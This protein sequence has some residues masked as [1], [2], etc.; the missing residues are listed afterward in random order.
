MDADALE[1]DGYA[2]PIVSALRKGATGHEI[3]AVLLDAEQEEM[4]CRH[5]HTRVGGKPQY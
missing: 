2:P 4:V 1:Y 3:E 5:R